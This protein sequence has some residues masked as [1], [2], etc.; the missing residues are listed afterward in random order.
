LLPSADSGYSL[1]MRGAPKKT[2]EQAIITA[3]RGLFSQRGVEASSV[4]DIATA[5]G[6]A[7][8]TFYLYFPSKES[9]VDA[10]FLPDAHALLS[11]VAGD[12]SRPKIATIARRLL[13]FFATRLLFLSEL[14]NSYR[15]HASYNY[16]QLARGAFVPMTELYY[17]RDARYEVRELETYSELI[18]GAALDLCSYRL[19]QGRIADDATVLVML[20]DLLKRFF[21]CEP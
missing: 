14:R 2:S 19:V 18:V 4:A 12:G 1:Q 20:E 8:G 15:G 21:D 17:R 9:L 6:T 16:V 5:A 7:K 10:L 13:D 11:A 3:A